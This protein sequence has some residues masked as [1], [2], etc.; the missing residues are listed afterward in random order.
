MKN[1][2]CSHLQ[3]KQKCMFN[4]N[5]IVQRST[6]FQPLDNMKRKFT[7]SP[8]CSVAEVIKKFPVHFNSIRNCAL[9]ESIGLVGLI[10]A[11]L[12][13]YYP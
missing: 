10:S 5:R 3:I 6:K 9:E 8:L 2:Q 4:A 1:G 11:Y 13:F 7:K 12:L